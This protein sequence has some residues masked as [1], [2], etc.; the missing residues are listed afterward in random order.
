MSER[1]LLL[2]RGDPECGTEGKAGHR[3]PG[4]VALGRKGEVGLA[5][6]ERGEVRWAGL[7]W[8]EER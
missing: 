2:Y 8:G 3:Q 1:E 7:C 6:V 5:G 4:V